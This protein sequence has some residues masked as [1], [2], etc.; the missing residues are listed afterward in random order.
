LKDVRPHSKLKA[1][2]ARRSPT[3]VPRLV[4]RTAAPTSDSALTLSMAFLFLI[5]YHWKVYEKP[6][7][8]PH[9]YLNSLK[10]ARVVIAGFD[11][12]LIIIL[13]NT[14]FWCNKFSGFFLITEQLLMKFVQLAGCKKMVQASA[15]HQQID[16]DWSSRTSVFLRAYTTPRLR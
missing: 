7:V 10:E 3:S 6:H 1:R 12:F 14:Y 4:D 15:Q 5:S 11:F 9:F 16:R 8:K 2:R 13:Y